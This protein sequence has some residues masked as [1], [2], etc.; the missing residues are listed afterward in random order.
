VF[1]AAFVAA[2]RSVT[3][4]VENDRTK[5]SDG[6]VHCA[7]CKRSQL[8]L[9]A[10]CPSIFDVPLQYCS[11]CRSKLTN[12]NMFAY[13]GNKVSTK[14]SAKVEPIFIST[15]AAAHQLNP[16]RASAHQGCIPKVVYQ[17]MYVQHNL[18][19]MSI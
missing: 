6:D 16:K 2:F 8:K 18:K 11:T 14:A 7:F 10:F 1:E 5:T 4:A 9:Q 19:R 12:D 13:S 15:V 17:Y 3:G